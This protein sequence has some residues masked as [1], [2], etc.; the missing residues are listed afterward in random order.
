[1]RAHMV[2]PVAEDSQV[3]IELVEVC[4][5]PL[6]ELLFECAEQAFDSAVLPRAAWIGKLVADAELF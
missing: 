5:C 3:G 6:V 1:M 4:Y 2:V